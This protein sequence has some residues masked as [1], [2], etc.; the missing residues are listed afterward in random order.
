MGLPDSSSTEQDDPLEIDTAV[1]HPARRYNYWLGG[2]QNFEADRISGDAVAAVLPSIRTGVMENRRFLRRA[3]TYVTAEA[4]IRQF[5]DIGTGIPAA[6]NVHE[7][8]QRIA[9]DTRVVY[10]DN[11]PIVLAHAHQLLLTSETGATAYIHAD[12][13]EPDTIFGHPDLRATL[14]LSRPVALMLI[15]VLHFIVDADDPYGCLARLVERLPPGSYVAISHA[16]ADFLPP[17][18]GNDIIQRANTGS[19]DQAQ[20]RDRAA[21]AQFFNGMELIP[22]GIESI[23]DWRSELPPGKRPSAADALHYGAVAR[24][25]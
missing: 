20:W 4:G 13:R 6:D 5:L 14:D 10:M 21:F 25:P 15:A 11:D 7:V 24:I 8:A 16:T 23:S 1:A 19:R 22:P 2:T 18:L 17:E 9:P 12:L 3:V